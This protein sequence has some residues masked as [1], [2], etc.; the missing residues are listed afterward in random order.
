MM[1]VSMEGDIHQPRIGTVLTKKKAPW[2][3]QQQNSNMK[4]TK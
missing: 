4:I 1:G 3:K 2:R